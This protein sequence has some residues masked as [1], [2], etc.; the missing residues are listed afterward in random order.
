M[1]VFTNLDIQTTRKKLKMTAADLAE[2]VGCEPTTIYNYERG[3]SDPTPDTMYQ[4][5]IAFEDINIWHR[6]MRTKY[7]SYARMHPENNNYDLRGAVMVLG[8]EIQDVTG[9]LDALIYDAASGSIDDPALKA[10]AGKEIDE[11]IAALQNIKV[12]IDD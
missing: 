9:L 3:A 7:P 10:K 4:I 1:Q 2:L 6:W 12:R 11:L 8:K 5:A